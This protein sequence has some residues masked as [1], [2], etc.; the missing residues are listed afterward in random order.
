MKKMILTSSG[1]NET[2]TQELLNTL[3]KSVNIIRCLFIPT[4]AINKDDELMIPVYFQQ[5]VNIGILSGN[6]TSYNCNRYLSVEELND[7]DIIF[8]CDGNLDFLLKKINEVN[9]AGIIKKAVED[10]IIYIGA[11]VGSIIATI[12]NGFNL[13]S[14]QVNVHATENISKTDTIFN[15][16]VP[17][18]L[19]DEQAIIVSGKHMHII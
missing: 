17:I 9:I 6:I 10:K 2:I 14:L 16:N 13:V 12:K 4:A 3:N 8:V 7:Y 18:N 15:K 5:L 11:G 1:M 19:A